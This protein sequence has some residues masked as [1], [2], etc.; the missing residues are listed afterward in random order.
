MASEKTPDPRKLRGFGAATQGAIRCNLLNQIDYIL[1]KP[2]LN[3]CY[4]KGMTDVTEKTRPERKADIGPY[5]NAEM[6]ALID[7]SRA[8]GIS[9]RTT[10]EIFADARQRVRD[11]LTPNGR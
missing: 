7:E 1:L 2:H 6:K 8:S 11:K 4:N 9:S 5:S 10:D 3:V